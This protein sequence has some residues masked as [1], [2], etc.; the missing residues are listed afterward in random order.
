MI[1]NMQEIQALFTKAKELVHNPSQLNTFL[2]KQTGPF[3]SVAFE[4]TAMGIALKSTEEWEMFCEIFGAE[5]G[6]QIH[7]GL[8]WALCEKNDSLNLLTTFYS[9]GK[10][11]VIDGYGYYAGLFKRRETIRKQVIPPQISSSEIRAFNQGVGRS[12]WYIS[13]ASP[14]RVQRM[15]DLFDEERRPDMWR[16]VGVSMTYVG[17]IDES[18][19]NELMLMSGQYKSQLM[20]GVLFALFGRY[21]A[22]RETNDSQLIA[23][24]LGLD[25][26]SY[27]PTLAQYHEDFGTFID[28]LESS[29]AD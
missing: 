26:V 19:V 10:W 6:S 23:K 25:Y 28:S 2:S 14:E 16:G 20:C 13:Q 4:G 15:I 3:S 11:K 8:G 27:F 12:L 24:V 22:N 29:L 1:A 18:V 7:V 17:G 9:E 21:N 5:H